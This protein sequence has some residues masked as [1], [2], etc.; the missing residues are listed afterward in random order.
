MIVDNKIDVHEVLIGHRIST[1][2]NK[3]AVV[4]VTSNP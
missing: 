1:R 2:E 4:S 3:Q